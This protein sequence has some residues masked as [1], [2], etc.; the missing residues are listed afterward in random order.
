MGP[1]GEGE[2]GQDSQER[3]AGGPRREGDPVLVWLLTANAAIA[4][5]AAKAAG[6]GGEG[7]GGRAPHAAAELAGH[8]ETSKPPGGSMDRKIQVKV[9]VAARAEAR[10]V[11][12]RTDRAVLLV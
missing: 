10:F 2:H 7:E 9:G 1:W 4:L 6:K 8:V 12:L 3:D 5:L 11:T